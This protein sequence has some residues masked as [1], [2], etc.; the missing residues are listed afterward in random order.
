MPASTGSAMV[1]AA[2]ST[3]GIVSRRRITCDVKPLTLPV[4]A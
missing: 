1:A 2:D 3:P 4:V